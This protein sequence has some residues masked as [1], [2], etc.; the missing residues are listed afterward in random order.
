MIFGLGKYQFKKIYVLYGLTRDVIP[1]LIEG[2]NC[3]FDFEE[4]EYGKLQP[5]KLYNLGEFADR[6]TALLCHSKMIEMIFHHELEFTTCPFQELSIRDIQLPEGEQEF[7]FCAI[8]DLDK[9]DVLFPKK[10]S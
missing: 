1:E 8:P 10:E 4:E 9:F 5:N 2:P 7:C 6:Q 3:C